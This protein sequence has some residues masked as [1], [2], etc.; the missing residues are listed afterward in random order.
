MWPFKKKEKYP[1]KE[2]EGPFKP[3][4]LE[5]TD[6]ELTEE[7][8]WARNGCEYDFKIGC[9]WREQIYNS[10]RFIR[11]LDHLWE[12]WE[13]DHESGS[14]SIMVMAANRYNVVFEDTG[15]KT[16]WFYFCY[17]KYKAKED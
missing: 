10:R 9:A 16:F 2:P 1:V 3:T 15:Q 4:R 14:V 8:V 12:V 11:K 17:F 7:E 13:C 5:P 6:R